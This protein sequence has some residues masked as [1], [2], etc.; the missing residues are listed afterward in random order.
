MNNA[1]IIIKPGAL[2]KIENET[3]HEFLW[4]L[5][6]EL[7]FFI[8]AARYT[9]A[10]K[11]HRWDG[12][13][14]LLNKNLSF[15]IGLLQR[16][17]NFYQSHDKEYDLV[18]LRPP[19]SEPSPISIINTLKEMNK[20]PY[21]Y[22]LEVVDQVTN[23]SN[24]D[25]GIIRVATGGGKTLIMALITAKLGKSTNIFVI[26]RDLLY[27]V[28]GLF[29]AAFKD[30]KIGIIGDG[31]CEIADIN[32]IS[33]WTAGQAL[34]FNDTPDRDD[35]KKI[36]PEK[37][38]QIREIIASAKV[39]F[40]DE[41]HCASCDT[42]RSLSNAM[43]SVEYLWGCSAS[44]YRDSADDLLIEAILGHKI[45]DISASTL[46]DG[47]FLVKPIIRFATVPPQKLNDKQYK[48]I[49]KEY[50]VE[51]DVRNQLVCDKTEDLVNLGYKTLVLY[52]SLNHG[53]IL[54]DLISQKIPCVL[55]S[56]KDDAETRMRAKEDL[57]S[58]KIKCIAA[59]KIFDLGVDIISL[60]GLVAAGGG[61][62][63]VRALQRIGRVIRK[64]PNKK[65]AAVV[66]FLDQTK[67]LKNHSKARYKIYST[68]PSFDVKWPDKK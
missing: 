38:A 66:D 47:G 32:V 14:K 36:E 59:S 65:N 39:N 5:D 53:K 8:E 10:F 21:P 16:V 68:E 35:E 17:E 15:Q 29:S 43:D 54:Y 58:G 19:K 42:I 51:N 64:A 46:I 56:G 45:V 61:K 62:S 26:G 49:Y 11:A 57:E 7:S 4:A 28:H 6:R 67:H 50:I 63:S 52:E 55:L 40:L 37:Y 18:D 30:T 2:C 33:V 44:P 41:S 22:Q 34:D 3:D 24:V 27:Q 1:Q 23:P 48:T 60:S 9:K 25:H 12:I 20:D 13:Q 31:K